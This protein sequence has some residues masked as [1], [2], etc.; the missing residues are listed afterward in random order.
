MVL[1]A[2][3]VKKIAK[4]YKKSSVHVSVKLIHVFCIVVCKEGKQSISWHWI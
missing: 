3:P 2:A 1:S 4:V